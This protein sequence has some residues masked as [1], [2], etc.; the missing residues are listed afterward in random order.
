M[1]DRIQYGYDR[2]GNRT[3]RKNLVAPENQD[4]HYLYDPLY[5]VTEAAR[6]NLNLN[7]TAI[8]GIPAQRQTFTYDPTGNWDHYTTTEDGV[9]VLDQT[10]I[11]NQANQITQIDGSNVGLLYDRAGNATQMPPD[12]AGDWNQHYKLTWDA[13][14]RLVRVEDQDDEVI[15]SYAYDGTTRRTTKTVGD[16]VTNSYYNDNWKALEERLDGSTD[17]HQQNLWGARP[18]HRDE[19]V[20]RDRDADETGPLEEKLY[21][22]MDYFD[23]IA[24][25][26][27]EGAVQ[28]RYRFS[29]FGLRSSTSAD[30]IPR[31]GSEFGFEFG[32]HGQLLDAETACYNYGY[33]YYNG[34][35]GRW[36][37]KDPIGERGGLNHYVMAHNSPPNSLDYRGLAAL[38]GDER[39][40]IILG[41]DG[42]EPGGTFT[43]QGGK[44]EH[45]AWLAPHTVIT[46]GDIE[47]FIEQG[48][49]NFS[50]KNFGITCPWNNYEIVVHS[51][52]K[53]MTLVTFRDEVSSGADFYFVGL[54]GTPYGEHPLV[55]PG[56][57]KDAKGNFR[58]L[59]YS[60]EGILDE[61]PVTDGMIMF[62]CCYSAGVD[63]KK[64]NRLVK[65]IDPTRT[66]QLGGVLLG[67][68]ANAVEMLCCAA[69][70][71]DR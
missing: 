62:Q 26:D 58:G 38:R 44:G 31:S 21:C 68:V 33:R 64:V 28:E 47:K 60:L 22:L 54:H 70:E 24:V 9:E 42:T 8:G 6:G 36:L 50:R 49:R 32:F 1:K 2:A 29:V 35:Q 59:L 56:A 25:T 40:K 15:A 52:T 11:H 14:N 19:L 30:W 63:L 23:P 67:K 61:T 66:T 18:H 16:L 71:N 37:S 53:P 48:K 69:V 7:Q 3:W 65:I 17:A 27:T 34:R 12:A 46:K 41:P 20:R 51:P 10:R 4:Q 13:W 45:W 43:V 5:Q 55:A 39:I 57:P